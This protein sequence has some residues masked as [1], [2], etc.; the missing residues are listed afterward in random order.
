MKKRLLGHLCRY[1]LG[2][3][4]LTAVLWRHWSPGSDS[5]AVGIRDALAGPVQ[6]LPLLAAGLFC[7]TAIFLAFV[8][9]Y[10]LVRARELPFTL[11]AAVRLGLIGQVFNTFL[12]GEIGSDLVKAAGIA[13]EQSRRATA[14]STV[15]MDRVVGLAGL[16]WLA[17]L[18]G[19]GFWA[20]GH[21]AVLE[22][23]R[24]Q[25]LILGAAVLVAGT[26]GVWLLLGVVPPGAAEDWAGRIQRLPGAGSILSEFWRSLW[27]YRFR[28][29]SVA[30]AL[31]LAVASHACYV[32]TF[33]SAAQVFQEPGRPA[34]I[35]SLAEHFLLIPV[36]ELVQAV[37]PS[38][39][40]AGAAEYGY[41]MLYLLVG[42]PEAN[43]V[44]AALAYRLISWGLSLGGYLAWLGMRLGA[45]STPGS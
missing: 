33:S 24:L 13:R 45:A 25:W 32:L 22:Q 28:G 27:A 34:A 5:G 15:L 36:G 10:V 41:G 21:P 31:L 12:G 26:L 14:V 6:V 4:V 44:L 17:T 38:P 29:G 30:L 23:E 37:F 16:F 1:A 3:G 8:R 2:V 20:L 40:G 18:V 43:G 7:A 35:P 9:W 19:G 42:H 11:R 39:G